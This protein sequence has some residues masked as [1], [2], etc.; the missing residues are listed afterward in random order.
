MRG[1]HRA[2]TL[3]ECT[4]W[5]ACVLHFLRTAPLVRRD[6]SAR[7]YVSPRH[8]IFTMFARGLTVVLLAGCKAEM[9]WRKLQRDGYQLTFKNV[10]LFLILF[11]CFVAAVF[12]IKYYML[13]IN[14]RISTGEQ[15]GKK[16]TPISFLWA[17]EFLSLCCM[18][19]ILNTVVKRALKF[20][21]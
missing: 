12:Q 11:R 7:L 17:T 13:L 5:P 1:G 21:S 6:M 3:Y 16:I 15:R 18:T 4:A 8:N 14:M 10:F 20:H 2:D 9:Q 19:K